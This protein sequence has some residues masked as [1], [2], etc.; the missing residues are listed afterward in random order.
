[1]D[2]AGALV[3]GLI[4]GSYFLPTIVAAFR[5]H[6]D[7]GAIFLVNLLLGWTVLGWLI[8]LIWSATWVRPPLHG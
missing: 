8:A 1:M 4:V 7:F 5:N 3:G 6:Y 2:L